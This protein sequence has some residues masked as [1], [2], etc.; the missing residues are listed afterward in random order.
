[1]GRIQVL[2]DGLIN[3][4]AAGEVV[5]RPASVVKELVENA[6]DAGARNIQVELEHGGLSLI[7][8]TDDGS[9]MDPDDVASCLE[10]HATSKLRDAAGLAAIA[11]LGFRGEAIPAI[12]SVSRFRLDSCGDG[13]GAGTRVVVEGGKLLERVEVGRARGTTVE[14]RDLFFNTPARRKFMK[15]PSTE[16]GHAGE[17]LIRVALANPQIGFSLRSS[18]RLGWVTPPDADLKE[19]AAVALGSEA[20]PHLIPVEGGRGDIRV[21]GLA[22]SP[23]FSQA[24]QRGIYLLVNGRFARDRGVAHAV[25][26]AYAETM[27]SGRFPAVVILIEMPRGRVDV[28]VHPQKLEVRFADAREVYDAVVAALTETLRGAPWLRREERTPT[29]PVGAAPVSPLPLPAFSW[30]AEPGSVQADSPE[31]R[32]VAAFPEA[33]GLRP[34]AL[35]GEASAVEAI[36]ARARAVVDHPAAAPG[37]FASLR[38]IGQHA[39]TYLLCEAPGGTLV[40]I[41]QHASHERLLFHRFREAWRSRKLEVQPFLIPQMVSLPASAARTLEAH[42][43]EVRR[44]GLEVE[45]FGGDDFAVKGA[46]AALAGADLGGLLRDLAQQ[47]EQSGRGR[48]VDDAIHDLLATIACHSAVRAHEDITPTEVRALLDGLDAVE[49]KARCPHGR[50]VVFELTLADLERRVGRR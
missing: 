37:Y 2:P 40:I 35:A 42:L 22:C 32:A 7:R 41:D 45:P 25:M 26:R 20:G 33:R 36:L 15:A 16:S 9:G 21:R 39:R 44:L 12:A 4:I 8:V 13:S 47:L 18:G 28:N 29:A 1:V 30:A 10:R 17:A 11:T 34:E 48:A 46:L 23:D 31:S 19:R 14:V 27:P 50:P 6:V 3:Q 5:E 38:Y 43:D 24:T 49:F